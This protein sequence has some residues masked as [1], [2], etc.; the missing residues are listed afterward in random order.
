MRFDPSFASRPG[1]RMSSI[2]VI[3]R[4]T[5]T[6]SSHSPSRTIHPMGGPAPIA[7]IFSTGRSGST[8]L[9]ALLGTHP[10][11]AYRFEP[12]VRSPRLDRR[13]VE[14]LQALRDPE[15]S[16]E[17]LDAARAGLL[18]SNPYSDKPP[19]SSRAAGAVRLQGLRPYLWP[20]AR[21]FPTLVPLWARMFTPRECR[22]VLFKLVAHERTCRSIRARTTMPIIYLARH[23]F[24]MI[25]SLLEGQRTGMMPS[26]RASIISQFLVDNAPH[27][28]ERFAAGLDRMGPHQHEALLWRWSTETSLDPTVE[29]R[30]TTTHTVFYENLCRSTR[31]EIARILSLLGLSLDPQVERFIQAS[32]TPAARGIREAGINRYFSVFRDPSESMTKWQSVLS[33]QE[34]REIM[35][36]VNDSPVFQQGVAEAQWWDRPSDR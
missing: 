12:T 23:P 11:V 33:H 18:I 10:D 2:A 14:A 8:W 32:T 20:L 1:R 9:G 15:I 26:G 25:S 35:E 21:R 31:D 6:V 19:F 34:Q 29:S 5:E 27:L 13:T 17:R 16:D 30:S 22:T 7:G 24:G 36:V 4:S 28:H 3:S